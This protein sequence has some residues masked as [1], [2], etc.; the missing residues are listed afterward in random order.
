VALGLRRKTGLAENPKCE[1]VRRQAW[2]QF[3]SSENVTRGGGGFG[4]SPERK[5]DIR[6][7]AAQ[8]DIEVRPQGR[9]ALGHFPSFIIAA[10]VRQP[11]RV[12]EQVHE[13]KG[14]ELARFSPSIAS[15]SARPRRVCRVPLDQVGLDLQ[16]TKEGWVW[17]LEALARDSNSDRY[18][19][20]TGGF[21]YTFY[22]LFGSSIDAGALT[23]I[24]LDSRGENAPI[25]FNRDV[26]AGVRLGWNDAA[27]TSLIFGSF[28]DAD[29]GSLFA[30]LEFERR[31]GRSHKLELQVQKLANVSNK[32]P[33]YPL[34]RDSYLQLSLS[35]YF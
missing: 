7:F 27:D 17:K 24:Y 25:P 35:R 18:S 34:R 2:F 28:V 6:L 9:G 1:A 22:G 33:L 12:D 20:I 21:E 19:A 31:I 11:R 10:D 4:V 32:D 16:Y 14:I 30:H 13:V 26:F 29:N 8:G 15:R 3:G 5:Q 23:E